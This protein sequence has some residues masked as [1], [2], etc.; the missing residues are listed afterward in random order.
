MKK[1]RLFDLTRNSA[2]E[3][4]STSADCALR[5]IVSSSGL[6]NPPPA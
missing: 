4:V 5:K 2:A 1:A 6:V 3:P